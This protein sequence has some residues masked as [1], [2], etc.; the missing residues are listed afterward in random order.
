MAVK[1]RGNPAKYDGPAVCHPVKLERSRISTMLPREQI[2]A[3][4]CDR[5]PSPRLFLCARCRCQVLVCRRCDRG[6]VYCGRGCAQ[7]ARRCNQREARRRYQ[8]TERGREMHADRSR[9]YRACCGRVTD[10]GSPPLSTASSLPT[11][12]HPPP[13]I[14]SQRATACHL[15]GRDISNL[16]RLEPMR[17]RRRPSSDPRFTR[18]R[19]PQRVVRQNPA[20]LRHH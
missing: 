20:L 1:S 13:V 17:R 3:S 14:A 10:Q 2:C 11:Q 16:V 6:Q 9:R 19:A 8:A 5:G 15:C 7:E 12:D 18:E 4:G